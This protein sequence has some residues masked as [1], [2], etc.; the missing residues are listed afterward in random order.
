MSQL[1][2]QFQRP[3]PESRTAKPETRL[4]SVATVRDRW[5]TYSSKGLTPERLAQ[6]LRQ[7]DSGDVYRQAELFEEM[8]EKD[9]HLASQFQVRKLAVQGLDWELIPKEESAPAR[10]TARFCRSFLENL[11]DFDENILD[12]LDAIAK[13]YSMLEI[14]WEESG[15]EIGIRCL[16]WIPA[17][18]ITF[19]ESLAPRIRTEDEPVRGMDPPPFKVVYHRY[20]ARSGYDT[21]AGIMRVCAWMYL[22]KNYAVKDWIGFAEVYGMPLRVGKYEP[23]ASKADRDALVHAVRSLGSDAAG[24][25]SKATEIEF[26]EAQ[27]GA[28]LDVYER[29]ASFCDAQMSKAILGQTLTSEAGGG[30]GQGSYALGRVHSEVRQDLVRADCRSLAKTITLQVLRPLVGF[31]FGWDAPVPRFQFLSEPPEDLRTVAEVYKALSDLGF[32]FSREHLEARF[33]I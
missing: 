20:K 16:N 12:L 6:I 19:T 22:F 29:L 30:K 5:S 28:S 3:I 31:N 15:G 11:T 23:G 33:K 13:G 2:D 10:E 14:L 17:K 8:E 25:I 27:K 7:A 21:R 4:L 9:A 26:I 32:G 18:R 1:Y 24:I